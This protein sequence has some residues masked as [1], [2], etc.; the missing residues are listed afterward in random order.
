MRLDTPK[1]SAQGR[2]ALALINSTAN[3]IERH[4]FVL[5][6]MNREYERAI[7]VGDTRSER[8]LR[9]DRIDERVLG[10]NDICSRNLL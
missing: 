3:S 8:H 5:A 10:M 1:Q 7:F 4:D 9:H 6:N 2:T